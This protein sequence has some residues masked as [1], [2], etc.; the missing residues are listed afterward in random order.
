M[1]VTWRIMPAS[2]L[3]LSSRARFSSSSPRSRY[4]LQPGPSGNSV[5]P[6]G[7]SVPSLAE[8]AVNQRTD[9]APSDYN[10]IFRMQNIHP[11]CPDRNARL[12]FTRKQ[13]KFLVSS[14]QFRLPVSKP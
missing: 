3:A 2:E 4:L 9:S 13:T 6:H 5:V 11:R 12:L 10:A 1:R 8:I 7:N 14:S